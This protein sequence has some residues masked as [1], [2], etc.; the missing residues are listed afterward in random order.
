[1]I[2]LDRCVLDERHGQVPDTVSVAALMSSSFA[3]V[4]HRDTFAGGAAYD[5][6]TEDYRRPAV[7]CT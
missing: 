4:C 5:V 1:M 3:C 7:V 6:H 2:V